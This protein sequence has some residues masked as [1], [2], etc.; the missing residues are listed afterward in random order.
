MYLADHLGGGP[1]V[2]QL[3]QD[4]ATGGLGV[5]NL[6]ISPVSGQSGMLGRTMGEIFANFSI[7]AVLDSDQGIYGFSNLGFDPSVLF[8]VFLSCTAR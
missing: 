5:E 1:A 3:V 7:A 4:S 2:R 8:W 6:A